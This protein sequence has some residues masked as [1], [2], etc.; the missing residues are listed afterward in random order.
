MLFKQR[1]RMEKVP[2][3]KKSRRQN[4]EICRK[5]DVTGEKPEERGIIGDLEWERK[6]NRQIVCA[7]SQSLNLFADR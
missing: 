4:A 3:G 2:E 1:A 5:K 7:K 6:A